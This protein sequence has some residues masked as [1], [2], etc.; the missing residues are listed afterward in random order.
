MFQLINRILLEFRDCFKRVKTWQW[1]VVLVLGFMMRSDH[2]GVTSV[3]SAL[4]LK[5][6]L[7]H[8]MLHFFRSTG[9]NVESL[10]DKWIKTAIKHSTVKRIGGRIVVLGD[11]SKVSKE[12]RRMPGIQV[13]HQESQNSGKPAYIEGHNFG[14]V[15]AVITN[16]KVSRSLPLITALQT[17]PPK[18]PG[19]KKPDGDTLVTQMVKLVHQA[20]KSLG[21]PVVAALDAYFCSEGAW[22]ACDKTITET[23]GRLVEIVTRA[24][25]NTVAY[26]TPE[27]TKVKKRG[28]PRKYGDRVILYSLFSDRSKFTKVTMSLY[29]K[30]TEVLYLCVDL[31]WRPV[32][33]LVRFV[34]VESDRGRCVLMSTSLNLSPEDIIAIYALR[35]KIETS[36]AEQKNDMGC[37]G[38]HFWTTALPKRKRWKAVTQP[39]DQKLQKRITETRQATAS[40]VCLCTIATGILSIIAFT[41]SRDIWTR[42]SGWIRTLRSTI[43]TVATV[44]LVLLQ[45]FHAFLK[46]YPH[47]PM[48]S[49]VN[50]KLRLIEFIFHDVA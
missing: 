42:Y 18:K 5:P 47:I 49:I 26:T 36:F 9:Y 22:T 40:F 34:V 25:T 4:K 19:T 45:D 7:Y 27:P 43:P 24:Q 48:C 12:G 11:H 6:K 2:R 14:Q 37:F 29:G 8:T 23:G 46:F 15:S 28:R 20:A 31:I 30:Q 50:S 3:I 13:L 44:K 39:S 16:D 38:Y 33:K 21:E 35:F 41:H 1:F 10:Y 32:K 17:S